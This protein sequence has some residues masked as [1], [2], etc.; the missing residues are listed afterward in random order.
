MLLTVRLPVI[1]LPVI[2]I[3]DIVPTLVILGCAFVVTVPVNNVA[4]TV[5]ELAY[6]LPPVIFAVTDRLA[7][8]PMLPVTSNVLNVPTEVTFG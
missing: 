6:T 4:F 7:D 2:L 1:V 5:P 3:S 8:V